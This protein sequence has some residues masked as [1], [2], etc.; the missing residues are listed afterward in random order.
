MIG[1]MR[2]ACILGR[3]IVDAAHRVIR[4]PQRA[5]PLD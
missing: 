1:R 5:Q 3:E 2:T 4:T